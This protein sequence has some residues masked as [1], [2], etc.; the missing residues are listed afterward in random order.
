MHTGRLWTRAQ[1]ADPPAAVRAGS[2]APTAGSGSH[3]AE[4]VS[5]REMRAVRAH[6]VD[7]VAD[8]VSRVEPL[9][10]A[11]ADDHAALLQ[12]EV[13]RALS[14]LLGGREE[15]LRVRGVEV[16]ECAHGV[17]ECA[18]ARRVDVCLE[19]PLQLHDEGAPGHGVG[20][21]VE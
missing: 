8:D 13:V 17:G 20:G 18:A 3:Q 19:V 16:D 11:R 2:V 1:D 15:E 9:R 5:S 6:P 10:G 4:A 14:H 21:F 7:G 12:R